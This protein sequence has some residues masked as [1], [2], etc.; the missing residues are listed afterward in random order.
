MT[1]EVSLN[2]LVCSRLLGTGG[3]SNVLQGWKNEQEVAVKYF[4]KQ[5]HDTPEKYQARFNNEIELHGRLS[6]CNI[7]A[8]LAICIEIDDALCAVQEYVPGSDLRI[9]LKDRKAV[10]SASARWMIIADIAAGLVHIHANNIVHNDI[11]PENIL[12]TANWHAKI[13]DFGIATLS[14][15]ETQAGTC[16]YLA[17]E[18]YYHPHKRYEK[19]DIHSF[20]VV[21][22]ELWCGT[23][24]TP[25]TNYKKNYAQQYGTIEPNQEKLEEKQ[26]F[27]M[28]KHIATGGKEV[29]PKSTPPERAAIIQSCWRTRDERPS[30]ALLSQTIF[31]VQ[32]NEKSQKTL[33]VRTTE[34]TSEKNNP[35]KKPRCS[36]S[37]HN[38][39]SNII[40]NDAST[41]T[42]I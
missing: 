21:L 24:A 10:L 14:G 8:L 9:R 5:S 15:S 35:S 33:N 16:E 28:K 36:L 27:A 11:K 6:H 41:C 30:A 4:T 18:C 26:L 19:S 39:A 13:T 20:G 12:V 40:S 34:T 25:F 31:A 7:V 38:A 32:K 3:F 1:P 23:G 37:S 29:I 17:P 2:D 42:L 22:W